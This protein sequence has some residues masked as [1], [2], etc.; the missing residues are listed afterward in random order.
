M[1]KEYI[2][3]MAW[4]KILIFLKSV[5]KIY[6]ISESKCKMFIEALYWMS[7]TGA[8]WRELPYIR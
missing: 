8:Q 2:N 3:K 4:S 7:R 1:Q 5:K 6:L